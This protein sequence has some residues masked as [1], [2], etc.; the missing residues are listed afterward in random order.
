[1][2]VRADLHRVRV[3]CDGTVVGDH[4]RC[5]AKHQTLSDLEHLVAAKLLR[6]GRF[7][8]VRPPAEVEVMV[9]PLT[10]YDTALGLGS[11]TDGG[12]A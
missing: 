12:A 6:R 10:D 8:L 1:M 4:A 11:G 3:W 9:R 7:D 5:W 2:L